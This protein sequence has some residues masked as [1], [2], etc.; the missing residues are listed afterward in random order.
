VLPMCF[1]EKDLALIAAPVL[2]VNVTRDNIIKKSKNI[3]LRHSGG[4]AAS[5]KGW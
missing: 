1:V 3:L 5:K 4:T 2:T